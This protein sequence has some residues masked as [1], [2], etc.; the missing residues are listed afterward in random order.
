MAEVGYKNPPTST[1]TQFRPG[2]SGNPAGRPKNSLTEGLRKLIFENE[3]ERFQA[4][5]RATADMAVRMGAKGQ[6]PALAMVWDR[7][8]GK[9]IERH[10]NLNVTTTPELLERAR[11]LLLEDKNTERALLTEYSN[12][13]T[14][15]DANR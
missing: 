10:M 2:Q 13:E 6:I 9:L 15:S 3:P 8:D 11:S 1:T 14:K 5:I 4:I 7:I 12:Q